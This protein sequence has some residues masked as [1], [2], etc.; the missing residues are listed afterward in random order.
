MS[1]LITP[2]IKPYTCQSATIFAFLLARKFGDAFRLLSLL[3]YLSLYTTTHD[4]DY[5]YGDY[6][7]DDDHN[8]DDDDDVESC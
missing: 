1:V 8:V 7:Y 3:F 4:D 6:D 5:D 2:C